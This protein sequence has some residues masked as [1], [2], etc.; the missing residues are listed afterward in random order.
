MSEKDYESMLSEVLPWLEHGD[1]KE[2]AGEL[3]VSADYVQ[4]CLS[5]KG[6]NRSWK[7]LRAAAEKA[8]QNKAATTRTR[9]ELKRI[10]A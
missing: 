10:G 8:K 3:E 9:E 4:R 2:I 5:P 6:R 7:V 1:R